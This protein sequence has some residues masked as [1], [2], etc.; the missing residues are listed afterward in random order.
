MANMTGTELLEL[1]H[2]VESQHSGTATLA[3][4][5]PVRE[6]FDGKSVWEGVV[7]VFDLAGHPT[8][9]RA[10]AWSSPIEGSDKPD[11]VIIIGAHLD[12]INLLGTK[13]TTKAPGADDDASG[14]AG[15]TEVLRV[16]AASG[17]KPRRTIKLIAYAAEEVGLRGSQEIAQ[18]YKKNGTNV[19]G[20]IQLDMTNFKG[21]DKDIYVFSDYTDEAQNQFLVKLV[22]AYLP[23][24]TVG[25]DKC[26][27]ACSDHAAWHAQGY[28][29]SMPFESQIKKDN[30]RIHTS[31]D[32]LANN[33]GQAVH[34]LKFARLAAA[35]A[36]E[37]GSEGAV[38]SRVRAKPRSA[39]R[40]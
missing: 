20:V 21:S 13:D 8:A 2:A 9:T 37:L 16:V 19:V 12:S 40:R 28:A 11:E 33:G 39:E 15:L 1:R 4:S 31:G 3:Q 38:A 23:T 34:S 36:V 6:T 32:T 35:Y 14:V 30:P 17:Y 7:H 24:L 25:Y 26:G 27:Y 29:T 5:V 10:Y 18:E 22:K